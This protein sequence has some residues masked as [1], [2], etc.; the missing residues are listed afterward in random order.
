MS[1]DQVFTLPDLGEGLTEAVVLE[2]LVAV[3]DTVEVDQMVVE[4]ETAKAAVE[5]PIPFA[6]TVVALHAAADETLAVGSAL[7][8]IGS[9]D[10]GNSSGA[11][12]A[13]SAVREAGFERH[14]EEERAGSGNVLIGFG[15]STEVRKR[16][17]RVQV[18]DGGAAGVPD[19]SA[20]RVISP[21]VRKLARE[22]GVELD[23]V[24]GTGAGGVITRADVDG[25]RAGVVGMERDSV[26]RTVAGAGSANGVVRIP[27]TG[28]RKA[29]ADKLATSRREIP[30]ATTWVDLDATELLRTR[31]TINATLPE[32]ERIGLLPLIARLMVAALRRYPDLN[33]TVDTARAEIVRYDHVHLGFAAQTPR[34]LVVPVIDH[35]DSLTTVELAARLRETTELARAG[36]LPPA[37]LTG[38]TI[39]LNNYG[40]FGVDGSTPIINHPEAAL[41]GIGRI[42]DRPWAL[43]GELVLRKVTQVSLT[44]DHRV[45]DGGTAGGFLRLFADYL[46]HP[47]TALG[48]M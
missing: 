29:I 16:R 38:G 34:G 3:G 18:V 5:V 19:R 10:G 32:G 25:V 8:T 41:L 24:V 22:S 43:D 37:R 28:V 11:A 27:L 46:E 47:I 9:S 26:A 13:E 45:C 48:R 1:V 4:V 30:D 23:S 42:I 6:G 15:T 20:S 40:V 36:K 44:F 17:R 33:A 12:D 7:I 39:T 31:A 35:A 21:F 14:R 2:W